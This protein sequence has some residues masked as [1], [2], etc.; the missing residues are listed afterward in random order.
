[1]KSRTRWTGHMI[2]MCKHRNVY[3]VLVEK[4]GETGHFEGPDKNGRIVWYIT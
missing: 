3:R 2:S 4:P 1:M